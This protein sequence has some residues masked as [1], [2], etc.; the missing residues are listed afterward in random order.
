MVVNPFQAKIKWL[1]Q[2]FAVRWLLPWFSKIMAECSK[3]GD[4]PGT[5]GES[6]ATAAVAGLVLGQSKSKSESFLE[7]GE[8]DTETLGAEKNTV[9]LICRSCQCKVLKPGYGKLVE[10]EV[11]KS[12]L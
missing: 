2:H 9:F 5:E 11:R 4:T 8:L 7:F 1:N 6:D 3:E 12:K 10:R